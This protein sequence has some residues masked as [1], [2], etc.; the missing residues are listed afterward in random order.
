MF[1]EYASVGKDCLPLNR[2]KCQ[3]PQECA[4]N[5]SFRVDKAWRQRCS[6]RFRN[7][8]VPWHF[9]QVRLEWNGW[10]S[11]FFYIFCDDI[12]LFQSGSLLELGSQ[13]QSTWRL[14]VC[15]CLSTCLF[16]Q[17]G[18]EISQNYCNRGLATHLRT[19]WPRKQTTVSCV[20]C[21]SLSSTLSHSWSASSM[22]VSAL[23]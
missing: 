6:Q 3:A 19:W 2:I 23:S 21:K 15:P 12:I 14:I 4:E 20:C 18:N 1:A 16:I 11:V 10:N 13:H 8:L 9:Q 7:I 5:M 17:L 22:N